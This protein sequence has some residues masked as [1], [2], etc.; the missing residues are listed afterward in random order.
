[1]DS[2]TIRQAVY[3]QVR[4][5]YECP[6]LWPMAQPK[7]MTRHHIAE[8]FEPESSKRFVVSQKADG[9]HRA[10][11]FGMLREQPYCCFM[12][13]CNRL[14]FHQVECNM[15]LFRGTLLLGEMVSTGPT[16]QFLIFDVVSLGGTSYLRSDYRERMAQAM[17]LVAAQDSG[18]FKIGLTL[19]LEAGPRL[20]AKP[21]YRIDRFA[22][23][24]HPVTHDDGLIFID[25]KEPISRVQP[26]KW[27]PTSTVDLLV[28]ARREGY[29]LPWCYS[30]TEPKL[31]YQ[32]FKIHLQTGLEGCA[33]LAMIEKLLASNGLLRYSVVFECL[34][35]STDALIGAVLL[36][37]IK[38][39]NDKL[40][41]N[42]STTV[43]GT[44]ES[45]AADIGQDEIIRHFVGAQCTDPRSF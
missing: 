23:D 3:Q 29:G 12:D 25:V 30:I 28:T 2:E 44:F 31:S 39:R 33:L 35:Q 32:G 7:D 43:L 38:V 17:D 13:R 10:L 36:I 18:A 22:T 11:I 5:H 20:A 9:I 6:R 16:A 14:V 37:P 8:V 26:L 1:M 42:T 45:F 34:L 24:Y 19:G 27:K 15:G 4:Q 40:Y 21:F 41:A